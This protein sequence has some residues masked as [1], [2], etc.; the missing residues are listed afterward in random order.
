MLITN[1]RFGLVIKGYRVR[2]LKLNEEVLPHKF[3][4][5]LNE[6]TKELSQKKLHFSIVIFR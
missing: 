1:T 5:M 4:N 6:S 3:S 2:N